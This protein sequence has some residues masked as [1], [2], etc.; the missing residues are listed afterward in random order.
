MRRSRLF[1]RSGHL[2]STLRLGRLPPPDSLAIGPCRP[3][4]DPDDE[5]EQAEEQREAQ[6]RSSD[7]ATCPAPAAPP[8]F[9]L[10]RS[11]Q[12]YFLSV[13][14]HRATPSKQRTRKR[15]AAEATADPEEASLLGG[16]GLRSRS[17][18]PTCGAACRVVACLLA[19][20]V[21]L[22]P[23]FSQP[24]S[25]TLCASNCRHCEEAWQRNRGGGQ[26]LGGSVSRLAR[27]SHCR[28]AHLPAAGGAEPWGGLESSAHS[29]TGDG[30]AGL[31]FAAV[32]GQRLL[33]AVGLRLLR[34][35]VAFRLAA[36]ASAC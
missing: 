28:A 26:G 15:S 10:P 9:Y 36:P 7:H 5:R 31:Y 21:R 12:L 25:L 6:V 18:A 19:E 35:A 23:S 22:L 17:C 32:G 2:R 33:G 4:L 11:P 1:L 34:G 20:P 30:A 16:L 29:S 24:Q 3:V 27:R 13:Q 14:A 8:A